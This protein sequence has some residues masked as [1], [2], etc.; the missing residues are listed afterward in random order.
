MPLYYYGSPCPA[1]TLQL[2]P[3]EAAS[4]RRFV[5]CYAHAL[6]EGGVAT[7]VR[8]WARALAANGQKVLVLCNGGRWNA[9]EP[10]VEWDS[11]RTLGRGA[12]EV[13]NGLKSVLNAGDLLVLHSGWRPYNRVAAVTARRASIP[14]V[15]TPHGAYDPTIMRRDRGPKQLWWTMMERPTLAAAAAVHVFF[16]EQVEH[17]RELGYSGEVIVAPNG[18]EAPAGAVWRGEDSQYAVWLGRIDIDCKGLDLLVQAWIR[19]PR[20]HRR[21]LRL[22]G[23]GSAHEA[24]K[25]AR[26]IDEADA[27]ES[28]RIM[29]PVYG[30][31]KWDVLAEA[32]LFLFPSRWDAHSMAVTEAA[33]VGLPIVASSSTFIG[34]ALHQTGAAILADPD[35][36]SL[37]RAITEA[38][39]YG[40]QTGQR[41]RDAATT[42]FSWRSVGKR[43]LEQLAALSI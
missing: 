16:P 18:V 37:A 30:P 24:Q 22:Y 29:P 7:S 9:N 40:P 15:L 39:K 3:T 19:L 32:S 6:S 1:A 42:E 14:Y 31:P 17:L 10:H 8:G 35:A 28:I 21:Q 38:Y 34:R 25:L 23:T 26:L 27:R 36:A 4:T 13:P 33:A 5:S 2:M 20:T 12:T 11:L 43:Y 41:A